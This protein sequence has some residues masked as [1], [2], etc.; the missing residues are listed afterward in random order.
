[1]TE[2]H[3]AIR[4]IRALH[5]ENKDAMKAHEEVDLDRF[6]QL[7]KR[8]RAIENKIWLATGIITAVVWLVNHKML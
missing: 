1:M 5:V 4:T 3:E 6:A 8:M 7:D 2:L